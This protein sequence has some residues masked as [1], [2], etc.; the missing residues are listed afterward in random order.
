MLQSA[1]RTRRGKDSKIMHI[2]D[3]HDLPVSAYVAST[4]PHEIMLV[5]ETLNVSWAA[6]NPKRL[7]GDKAY[8]S[9]AHD[10]KLKEDER[11]I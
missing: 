8:D 1:R 2:G 11:L 6:E 5:E 10:K 9:D 4:S 7:T 3:T